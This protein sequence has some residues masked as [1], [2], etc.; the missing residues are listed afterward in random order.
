MNHPLKVINSDAGIR[1]LLQW[2]SHGEQNQVIV[3]ASERA[4]YPV[5]RHVCDENSDARVEQVLEVELVAPS[6][7]MCR[8]AEEHQRAEEVKDFLDEV[9][10]RIKELAEEG[11]PLPVQFKRCELWVPDYLDEGEEIPPPD[12]YRTEWHP[13]CRNCTAGFSLVDHTPESFYQKYQE[14]WRLIHPVKERIDPKLVYSTAVKANDDESIWVA[15]PDFGHHC[16]G[17]SL[18]QLEPGRQPYEAVLFYFRWRREI[19]KTPFE[20]MIVEANELRKRHSEAKQET[21]DL[22]RNAEKADSISKT[23]AV[24]Q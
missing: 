23:L 17:V 12:S 15:R 2:W 5:F 16:H 20:Q 7:V 19:D 13:D 8:R 6:D 22:K 1:Y 24:F 4:L 10:F 14:N 11:H 3:A 18:Y 9:S 21:R